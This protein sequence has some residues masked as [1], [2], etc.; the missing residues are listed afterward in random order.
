MVKNL[1][2][3]D[4]SAQPGFLGYDIDTTNKESFKYYFKALF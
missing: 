4:T 3:A 1:P 2:F